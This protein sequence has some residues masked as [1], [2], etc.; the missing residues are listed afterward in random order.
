MGELWRDYCL[1]QVTLENDEN[2][3]IVSGQK[4]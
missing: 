3:R 2:E 4:Q 1:I